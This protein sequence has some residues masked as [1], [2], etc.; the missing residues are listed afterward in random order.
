MARILLSAYA[1]EPGRG[2]EPGVG[3]GWANELA[4]EGH[5]VTVL[6]RAANRAVIEQETSQLDPKLGFIYY[7]LPRWLQ[8]IRRFPGGKPAYYV[9]WQWFAARMLRRRFPSPPFDIVQ[10]VTYVSVRY[11]S[12]MG[13]LGI[14]FYFGPVS[15]GETVPR[16]LRA[17][18]PAGGRFREA[19]RDISNRLLRWD[20][21]VRRTLE[22]ANRIFV[23]RDTL[24]LLP[25]EARQR[26]TVTLAV[27]L[28]FELPARA[29]S[30]RNE[31]ELRLLYVG[32]LLDWKGID[33]ALQA[34]KLA[35]Q[36]GRN[37]S[38][39]IVGD[40]PAR[41]P[42]E[43]LCRNLELNE[44]V[45]WAGWVSQASLRKIYRDAD[46]LLFPSLRDSG[47]M[48]VL[49]ALAFGLP[50]VCTDLGGPGIIVNRICGR[51]VPAAGRTREQ[52]VLGLADAL[53]E[54]SNAGLLDVLSQGAATRAREFTFERLVR[55]IYFRS[56]AKLMEWPA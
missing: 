15:G 39:T 27:G 18:F 51:V 50:V 20:P 47:G 35:R 45:H 41:L 48:A 6:T 19:A 22:Q 37:V 55:T 31:P 24:T 56:V 36:T 17:G 43:R 1:C 4:R 21:L 10:H 52:I 30:A 46:V 13:T 12:F 25:D 29:N 8:G 34:I 44:C 32:R 3:W 9:L 14:P 11:P 7:D 33:L 40:G 42:L 23:T 26:A 49:E 2:S 54:I 38:L 53:L 5:H 16:A 28:P